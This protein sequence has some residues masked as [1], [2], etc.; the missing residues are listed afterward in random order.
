[1]WT[2]EAI[3]K[4]GFF[5][6]SKGDS[7]LLDYYLRTYDILSEDN[8]GYINTPLYFCTCKQRTAYGCLLSIELHK[9]FKSII[10]L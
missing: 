8:I 3:H 5:N 4:I 1:M 9:N 10:F 2:K 6:N 7:A